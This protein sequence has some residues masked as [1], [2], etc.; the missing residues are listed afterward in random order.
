[1]RALPPRLVLATTNRGKLAEVTAIL[2]ARGVE[3]VAA[4]A[5]VP[6]WHVAEENATFA[7]NARAKAVDLARHAGIPAL[8]DDS[9]LDVAALGGRPGVRS[10]RYAGEGASDAANTARLLEELRD[11]P[12][13]Q[14]AAVFRCALALAWPDGAVVEAE[15]SCEGT[16]ARTPR[17]SGGFGYDPIFVD[18]ETGLTF[19]ELP[20]AVKNARS[21][22]RR[23]LEALR[24]RLGPQ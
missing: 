13:G 2:G 22:R 15:G 9:G 12:E 23:A 24:A 17:G 14:R 8:G 3:V 1:M 18:P 6:D 21:H 11:V 20:A 19:A 10:A 4:V 16:I 7:E 5:L